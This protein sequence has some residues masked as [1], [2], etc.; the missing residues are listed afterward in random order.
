MTPVEIAALVAQMG[1]DW[2]HGEQDEDECHDACRALA[3]ALNI[4]GR[5][6]HAAGRYVWMGGKPHRAAGLL[7]EKAQ[8]QA[9]S[10]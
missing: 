8:R 3:D 5:R 6:A 1:S 9:G 10:D 4:N 2:K 7:I